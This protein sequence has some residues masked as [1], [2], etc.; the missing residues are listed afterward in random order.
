M[1]VGRAGSR[2]RSVTTATDLCAAL[3]KRHD[4]QEWW[5]FR[6]VTF[7]DAGHRADYLA[8]NRWKSRGFAL[9]GY[10][11]K[12]SRNDW[13][14]ELKQ[15][16]KAE[17]IVGYCNAWSIATPP[18]IVE[19]SE[20]PLG[21][22]LLEWSGKRWKVIAKPVANGA[23]E[24][25]RFLWAAMI[26]AHERPGARALRDA[27]AEGQRATAE[28]YDADDKRRADRERDLNQ[29]SES[30]AA[31]LGFRAWQL[32][33]VAWCERARA[34][35]TMADMETNAD[36]AIENYRRRLTELLER[37]PGSGSV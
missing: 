29:I 6:E 31:K 20:L 7:D 36:Q 10:E 21:W 33:D 30:A 9:H 34:L 17:T 32:A 13:L 12:V 25:P 1:A 27:F 22:G 2:D 35:L 14:R 24:I 15:P 11:V 3:D 26:R 16:A 19:V 18:G 23:T 5:T 4:D 37:C 28:R 8:L